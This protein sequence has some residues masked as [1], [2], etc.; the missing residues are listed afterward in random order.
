MKVLH[1]DAS[2][3][4]AGSVSRE[5]SQ[6]FIDHLKKEKNIEVDRLD[7]ATEKLDHIT[8]LYA[9]AMYAMPNQ[10]TPEQEKELEISNGLVDR[11]MDAELM[12]IGTPTYNFGIPSNLKTFI[13][14]TVRSG[15]TFMYTEA[16]FEGKLGDK[17]VVVINSRGLSYAEEETSGNDHVTGYLKTILGFVGITDVQF[18]HLDPTFFGEEATNAAKARAKEEFATI[19]DSL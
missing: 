14:L 1:I 6:A 19:V 10:Y 15:R 9:E 17:K 16:G 13:D 18:V 3:R 7:L 11:V 5:M 12:V 4:Q 8:Q 2:L